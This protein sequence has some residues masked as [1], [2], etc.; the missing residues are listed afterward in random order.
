MVTAEDVKSLA[1]ANAA[2]RVELNKNERDA[3]RDAAGIACDNLNWLVA[4]G[5]F[6]K[7]LRD[8]SGPI[9][10]HFARV[11]AVVDNLTVLSTPNA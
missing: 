8:L 11:S 9:Q 5:S 7:G 10:D 3:S 4:Q 6:W 1:K 2:I